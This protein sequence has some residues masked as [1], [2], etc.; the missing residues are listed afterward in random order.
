MGIIWDLKKVEKNQMNKDFLITV[1]AQ[2]YFD[3]V[4]VFTHRILGKTKEYAEG[5][6]DGLK[7]A[8]SRNQVFLEEIK[9]VK[10][11]CNT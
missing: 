5:V 10:D 1:E 11:E 2:G 6:R 3:H 4:P 9:I 8:Y 7:L